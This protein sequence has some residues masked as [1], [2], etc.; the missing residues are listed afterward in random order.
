MTLKGINGW[1]TLIRIKFWLATRG[2][3]FGEAD[4][5]KEASKMCSLPSKSVAL[6]GR[7]GA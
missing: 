7:N 2:V 4:F 6:S 3:S 1:D 5:S